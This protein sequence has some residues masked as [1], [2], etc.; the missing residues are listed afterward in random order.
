MKPLQ[1]IFPEMLS[2]GILSPFSGKVP[3]VSQV[4]KDS[5]KITLTADDINLLLSMFSHYA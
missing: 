4:K 1:W 3:G 2:L 5:S